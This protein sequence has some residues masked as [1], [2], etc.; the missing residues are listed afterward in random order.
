MVA[1]L[2]YAPIHIVE[3]EQGC[4]KSNTIVARAVDAYKKDPTIRIY[5]NF[6][7]YGVR[8]MYLPLPVMIEY[9]NTGLIREGYLLIDEG[10]IAGNAR[11]GMTALVRLVMKLSNQ[12]RKRHL[13]LYVATPNARQLDWQ[14]RWAKTESIIC[15]YNPKNKMITLVIKN[16]HKYRKPRIVSYYAPLYWKY[17]NTDE[18]FELPDSQIAKAIAGAS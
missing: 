15:S 18:Q 13:H 2:N 6:H 8:A 12:I 4:G 17:F 10:Y 3:G 5:A 7:L 11:E 9:L 16:K 14:L 1:P